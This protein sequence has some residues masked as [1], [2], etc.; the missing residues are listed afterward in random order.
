[1]NPN[2]TIGD[3]SPMY[4]DGQVIDWCK[5]M[6]GFPATA[7]G[8]LV[9]GATMANLTALTVARF[10]V[11]E[12]LKE[13]GVF[14]MPGPMVAYG[15]SET[16]A[17]VS[18]AVQVLGLGAEG[19]CILPVDAHYRIRP[20]DLRE[21]IRSDRAQGKIPFCIVA[22]AG[23]VNT[24]AIDPLQELW[25]IAR[26]E[27]LW[28][29]I[30]GAFG[31]MAKL[32]PA[33][34]ES[35]KVIERA[36]SLAFDLHKWLYMPYEVGCVLIR[37]AALQRRTFASAAN[38]LLAHDR[39]LAGGP[40]TISNKGIELS[41]GFKALKVWMSLK[42]HGIDKYRRQ[43]SRNIAQAMYLGELIRKSPE[44]ELLADVS[45]NIVCYR[46][47]PHQLPS[48]DRNEFDDLNE[49]DNLNAFNKE[50]LM[51]LHESGKAAPSYTLL[52]GQYAIRVAIT[53]HRTRLADM[54]ILVEATIEI[55]RRL[56][57]RKLTH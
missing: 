53:N 15:S 32:T 30:D 12:P 45:M 9:S 57:G 52:N 50:L 10:K 56:I 42:E 17:C 19:F 55:G 25:E 4:V 54:D 37:D 43:I 13:Q 7:G 48:P 5:E 29:H 35:L 11:L 28:L 23:T 27:N 16:H 40:E 22:N 14:G 36:D 26:E 18:K 41:R 46:Y 38:Y 1:M 24:G 51:Q 34:A 6:L 31:A 3:H 49:F 8:L 33:F 21:K 20:N 2:V 44:L 39:G 47:T